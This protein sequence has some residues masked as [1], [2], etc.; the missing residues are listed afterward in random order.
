[1]NSNKKLSPIVTELLLR[2]TKLYVSLIFISQKLNATHC[3]IMCILNKKEI[4]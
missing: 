4:Q 2:G 3:F 1:M